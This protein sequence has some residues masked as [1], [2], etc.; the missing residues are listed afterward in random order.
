MARGFIDSEFLLQTRWAQRLYH[1]HAEALPIFDY[2]C[3]LPVADIAQDRRFGSLAQAWL[4]GDHYKW[5]AMRACGVPERL[6]TG[7]APDRER[8]EAWAAAIP[9]TVGNPLFHWTHLELLRYFDIREVLGPGNAREIHERCSALLATDDFSARQLLQKMGVRVI[10]TTDNPA[11]SLEHHTA[12]ASDGS[13]P[14]TVLPAFRPDPALAVE[15]P[16]RFNAWIGRLEAA[17]GLRVED[18]EGLTAALQ[19]RHDAFHAAGCRISDLGIEEP[20]AEKF[21]EA[22]VRGAFQAARGGSVPGRAETRAFKSAVL[23]ELARMDA[24]A[25]W[26]MQ[27]HMAAL[28]DVNSRACARLGPN[29]GFDTIGDFAVVRPLA[30]LLDRLK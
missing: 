8:F 3:H 30:R 26:A 20:Y 18:F 22:G 27:L 17:A 7:D 4:A 9:S 13:F 10:C 1:G 25:G 11:D 23:L 24:R 29:T 14:V 6:V 12:L 16:A 5:R 2:H 28:R 21:T 15:H 19:A